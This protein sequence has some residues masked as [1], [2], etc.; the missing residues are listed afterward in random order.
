MVCA[1]VLSA[2]LLLMRVEPLRQDPV[3]V[4]AQGQPDEREQVKVEP[5]DEHLLYERGRLLLLG[6]PISGLVCGYSVTHGGLLL[7]RVHL[8]VILQ[9]LQGQDLGQKPALKLFSGHRG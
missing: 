4:V 5:C 3:P 8:F 1:L 7:W 2:T 6:L 9:R